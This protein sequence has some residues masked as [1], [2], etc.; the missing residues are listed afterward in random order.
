MQAPSLSE[1]P[2]SPLEMRPSEESLRSADSA[3]PTA[4]SV[5]PSQA[6]KQALQKTSLTSIPE[7]RSPSPSSAEVVTH[8]SQGHRKEGSPQEAV[9][10]CG[11]ACRDILH[12]SMPLCADM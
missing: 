9:A 11:H 5:E 2:L 10:C 7:V 1:S 8:Q 3:S 4:T 6:S 12:T